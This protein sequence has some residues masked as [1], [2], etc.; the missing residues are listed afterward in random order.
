[1]AYEPFGLTIDI[2][3]TY[4][5]AQKI[6]NFST[7]AKSG[8]QGGATVWDLSVIKRLYNFDEADDLKLKV[9][10]KNIFDK[11]YDTG[12]VIMPGSSIYIGLIYELK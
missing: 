3:G 4:L 2:A 11:N 5:G 7:Q 9:A 1:M 10:V 12:N 6:S 8:R